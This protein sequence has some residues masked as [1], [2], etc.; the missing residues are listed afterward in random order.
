MQWQWMEKVF[1][2]K[3]ILT[4]RV[5]LLVCTAGNLSAQA[6]CPD[7]TVTQ[8]LLKEGFHRD[9]LT[10]VELGAGDEAIGSCTVAIKEHLPTGLYVDPY[11]LAS[12]QQ[13][14]LTEALMFPDTVDVESPEYLATDLAIVVY[15]KPDPQCARCFKS[16]LPVHCRYHR[17][18]EDDGEALS[19]LKSPEILIHCHKS[20]PSVECW[21][22]SEVE[23]P[24]SV[25]NR[26]ICHWNNVK[27]KPVNKEVI[28]QVPVGLKQHGALISGTAM[29]TRM[30]PQY[31]NIFMADLE[32]RFL[33]SRPLTPLLYLRYIDD[34]FIIWTHGKAALEE[35]HH[36]FN[37][38]H[39]TINL[40]LVQSTHEIHFLD[41]TVLINDGHINTT[42]YRKPTDRY[43]YLHASSF[44]PDHTTRSIVYSQAL[45]YNR[46]CS[47]PS[48]R[49][50]HLQDLYQ[51]FLQLQYPPVE[52]KKQIDRARRAKGGL[53]P[54]LDLQEL[55]KFVK[56]LKFRMVSLASIIA[57]LDPADWYAAL[58]LKDAYFHIT[59]SQPHCKYLRF[60]R[61]FTINQDIF[62]L[63]FH[64]K[65]HSS[66]REQYRYFCTLM[67]S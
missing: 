17:P 30:A 22:Y 63:V 25:R 55:N 24:C 49:D 40:S 6:T 34:I 4:F 29:G 23:A 5:S 9:L 2:W 47:N 41:T 59:I 44:H 50:K 18:T 38:F 62:I 52:V 51:A 42:L 58:D 56:K 1:L 15:M 39:P 7:I 3:S 65:P 16:M 36:D 53:R 27:Y 35:F 8:Q 33:S 26:H 20:F 43:S 67:T 48:D 11:E 31:A 28:L 32:Q 37:N 61:S 60:C 12:L 46:I 57:S 45:R 14:N 10:K 64:S 54:I 19:L 21:K 66:G 13:H